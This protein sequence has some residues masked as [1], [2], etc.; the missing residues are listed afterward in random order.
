MTVDMR[1]LPA[2]C[3]TGTGDVS[4]SAGEQGLHGADLLGTG[5]ASFGHLAGIHYQ[6]LDTLE[7]Y[8]EGI[9]AG[10]LPLSRAYTTSADE[11]LVREMILQMKVGWLDAG[12]FRGKYGKEIFR[13][14]SQ[15][16]TELCDRGLAS[17]AADRLEFKREGLLRVDSLLPAF[18][19]PMHQSTSRYT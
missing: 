14:Y 5:V 15:P 10:K 17:I 3:W 12:Y 16:F 11:R 2:R 18:F 19:L 8:Q 7:T 13:D 6:N 4:R 1:W 9:A